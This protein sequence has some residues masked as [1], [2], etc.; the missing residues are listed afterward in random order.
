L[1]RQLGK[2]RRGTVGYVYMIPGVS[3][4][5]VEELGTS[6]P[7]H[8]ELVG[9]RELAEV[10]QGLMQGGD[11]HSESHIDSMSAVAAF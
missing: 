9:Y 8:V 11:K 1:A 10:S 7:D 3:M 2:Y 6:L 5:S 4:D